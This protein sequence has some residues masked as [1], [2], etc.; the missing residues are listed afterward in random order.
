MASNRHLVLLAIAAVA[1]LAAVP[2]GLP[3]VVDVDGDDLSRDIADTAKVPW[4]TGAISLA[5]LML[6]SAAAAICGFGAAAVSDRRRGD[7]RFLAATAVLLLLA[8]VDD[9]L[10]LHETVG[11]EEL[12]IPEL[13]CY[14]ALGVAALAWALR[15]RRE[16]LATRLWVLGLAAVFFAGSL[17]S[18]FLTIGPTAAEDWLK[19]SGIAILLL[20]CADTALGAV[21]AE[22]EPLSEL[23][24]TR[25]PAAATPPPGR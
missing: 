18:D 14:A 2:L 11:P 5:G 21:R 20:W 13:V 22:I 7:A 19:N 9:A 17:L 10:Q 23:R 24:P 1:V 3:L 15:F 6:W 25:A 4:W 16:I 12:G 8:A